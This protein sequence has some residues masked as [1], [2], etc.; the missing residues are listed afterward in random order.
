VQVVISKIIFWANRLTDKTQKPRTKN[1]FCIV[2]FL[3][4]NSLFQGKNNTEVPV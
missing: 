4:F 2:S 1:N 3:N